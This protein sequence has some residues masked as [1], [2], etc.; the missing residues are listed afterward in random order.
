MGLAVD[1]A[2]NVFI[3]DQ[4]QQHDR[5][6]AE[7]RFHVLITAATAGASSSPSGVAVDG[8]GN[9]YITDQG[10]QA[11]FELPAGG[12]TLITLAN[13]SSGLSN[14]SSVAVD[15]SGNA[16][17]IRYRQTNGLYELPR[18]FVDT[19]AKMEGAAAGSDSL[20]VVLP[21]MANLGGALA[22]S[23]QSWLTMINSVHLG[24][25]NFA[26]TQN[27]TGTNRTA[28]TEGARLSISGHAVHHVNL[29]PFG[30]VTGI[31]SATNKHRHQLNFLPASLV[32]A[33]VRGTLHESVQLGHHLDYPTHPPPAQL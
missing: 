32:M 4:G 29:P 33:T 22:P 18:A 23:S 27:T 6:I 21:A 20:P 5:R 17:Y 25:V 13:V 2:G 15:G 1:G 19:T 30:L 31:T 24:V 9:L 7:R 16:L 26:Y 28:S 14:P 12:S 3:A 10:A 8:S 11:L